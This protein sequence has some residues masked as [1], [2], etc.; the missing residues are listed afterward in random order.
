MHFSAKH[1]CAQGAI[2]TVSAGFFFVACKPVPPPAPPPAMETFE[3]ERVEASLTNYRRTPS[4]TTRIEVDRALAE[5]E[6]EINELDVRSTKVSGA[7]KAEVDQKA[8]DLRVKY[9]KYRA[10]F[11]AAQAEAGARSAGDK[12]GEALKKAGEATERAVEKTGDAIKDAAE[13]VGE[14]LNPNR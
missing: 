8:S 12:A 9:N 5:M 10:D 13:S 4:E 14:T 1:L 3:T 11:A 6:S 7:D 2:L